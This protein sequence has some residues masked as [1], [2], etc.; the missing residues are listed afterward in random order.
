MKRKKRSRLI[1]LLACCLLLTACPPSGGDLL[2]AA[3]E[4]DPG[5]TLHT[6]KV[7]D[8][9]LRLERGRVAVSGRGVWSVTDSETSV[10][11]EVGNANNAPV[12]VDFN[13]C[14]MVRDESGEKLVL[15]SVSD[16]T[17]RNGP[18]FLSQ[19]SVVIDGGQE[20]R[21]ALEFKSDSAPGASSAGGNPL[22]RSVSLHL[23]VIFYKG[24]GEGSIDAR[25]PEVDFVLTFKYAEYRV[26]G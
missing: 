15:R 25:F 4:G 14:E 18:S 24:A 12:T 17:G 19:K 23:P 5:A 26:Q 11:L 9:T 16:E 20:K 1:L 21:F 13:R 2:P 6:T 7:R 8:D 22:G 3:R 10:I